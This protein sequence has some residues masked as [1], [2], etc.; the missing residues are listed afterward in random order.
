MS[1]RLSPG[2]WQK[3]RKRSDQSRVFGASVDASPKQD[4]RDL[5]ESG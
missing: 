4:K 2:F 5:N 1:V 3:R